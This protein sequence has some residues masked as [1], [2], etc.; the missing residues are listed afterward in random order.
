MARQFVLLVKSFSCCFP[1]GTF[2]GTRFPLIKEIAGAEETSAK[3]ATDT[4]PDGGLYGFDRP[5]EYPGRNLP[6]S[7]DGGGKA[8]RNIIEQTASTGVF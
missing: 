2:G 3:E 6:R 4:L 5:T 8:G 7:A 1:G